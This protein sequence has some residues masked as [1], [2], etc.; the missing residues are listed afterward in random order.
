MFKPLVDIITTTLSGCL[1]ALFVYWLGM[2][3]DK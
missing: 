1:V 2:R 3:N